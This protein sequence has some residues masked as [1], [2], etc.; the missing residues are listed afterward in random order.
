MASITFENGTVIPA[1]WLNAVNS[2]IY[3]NTDGQLLIGTSATGALTKATLTAGTGVSITNGSG[4]ITISATGSGSGVSS[5]TASSPLASSGGTTPNISI[6]SST[7]SGAVVLATSPALVTPVLGTPASGN[8]GNCTVDG[9][10][11]V[12]YR[13]IP[14]NA[15]SSTP[16]VLVEGDAGKHILH[17]ASG[18]ATFTIPAASSVNYPIGTALTFVNQNGAGT[19]TITINTDTMYLAGT[20]TV[21]TRTLAANGIATALKIGSGVWI[22]SG[23][24]LT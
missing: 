22:I 19:L 17:S 6:S 24:G 2:V 14:Q 10:Y 21:G 20:G 13:N 16:Y 9:T 8:L 5:V 15:P 3:G 12:G 23:T 18:A 7:G 4:S 1:S 11:A